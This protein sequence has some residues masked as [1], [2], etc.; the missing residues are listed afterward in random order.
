M[1][2]F[3]KS[4]KNFKGFIAADRIVGRAAAFLYV[5][6]GISSLYASVASSGAVE[7]CKKYNI[8]FNYD[9]ITESI[10]NRKGD[11]I[12][13]MEKLVANIYEP[14]KAKE[15]LFNKLSGF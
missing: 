7:I 12:C 2:E 14:L 4:G 9:T 13:P 5:C 8:E 10:I 15:I 3:I 1:I 6:M 11:D